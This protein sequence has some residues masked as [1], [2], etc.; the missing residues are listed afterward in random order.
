[1][2]EPQSRRHLLESLRPPPGYTLDHA[3]GTTFSLD[4]LTLLTA[5]LA[6]TLFDWEDE[7]GQPSRDPLPLL[8]AVRRYA[9]RISIFCQAGRI[10]VPKGNQPLLSYLENSVFQVNA[11]APQGVFHP[12]VW[13]LRFTSPEEAPLYRLLCLSRNLTFDRAWDTV[14]VLEGEYSERRNAYASNHPLGNFVAELPGLATGPM[15]ERVRAAVDRAQ[16]EL[17]RVAFEPPEGFEEIYF[18]PLGI[19]GARRW[20]FAPRGRRPDRMLVV[21][22]FISAGCLNRLAGGR[23]GNLLISR[24]E[25]LDKLDPTS[26]ERFERVYV[27]NPAA[28]PEERDEEQE[29]AAQ[30]ALSGLHAKLYI[31]DAGSKARIWTGSANATD[32]A[33]NGNVEFLVELVGDKSRCGINSLLTGSQGQTSFIDM[34]QEFTPAP[35]PPDPDREKLERLVEQGRKALIS[36]SFVAH[37]GP[38]DEGGLFQISLRLQEGSAFNLPAGVTVRCWPVT[39]HEAAGITLKG[40]PGELA[41]FAPASFEAITSFF[42]FEVS[43]TDGEEHAAVRFALNVPL[44]GAPSDRHERILRSLLNDKDRVMRFIL[45]LLAE[46]GANTTALLLASGARLAGRERGGG[47]GVGFP[48]FEVL[49]RALDRD[50]AKLDQVARLVDDLRKAPEGRQLLP[51]G[52]EEVWEPIW[53]ARERLKV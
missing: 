14:L 51:E 43:A 36:A 31:A 32:A 2:L 45:L 47:T 42:A 49:V 29:E 11:R 53:A 9:S 40:S 8:E 20:P 15:P 19:E 4:L 22:P 26:F 41:A 16:Y 35:L 10:A 48:L 17:R 39:L 25:E 13:V 38:P 23:D 21:S 34:L 18:W 46:Q 37:V 27:L 30:E 24:P 5:P 1:M 52:F 7:E 12:K 28:Q 44:D 6:F 3:I 50:P 33:F